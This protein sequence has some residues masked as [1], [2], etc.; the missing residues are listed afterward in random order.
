M[1][2]ITRSDQGS[3]SGVFLSLDYSII[4]FDDIKDYRHKTEKTIKVHKQNDTCLF[5]FG[6]QKEKEEPFDKSELI[7]R[8]KEAAA[9]E[10]KVLRGWM[11]RA[12]IHYI[13]NEF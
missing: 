11:V 9:E 6:E 10:S 7:R 5:T 8:L 13:E 4:Y 3:M 1:E 2:Q 12:V